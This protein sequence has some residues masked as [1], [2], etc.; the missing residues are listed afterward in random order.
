MNRL[1]FKVLGVLL[2]TSTLVQAA[3][4]QIVVQNPSE[5]DRSH[6]LVEL[7]LTKLENWIQLKEGEV[8]E[9]HNRKQEIVP[10]QVT[11]DGLLLF[12]SG[13]RQNETATFTVVSGAKQEFAPKTY[14]RFIQERKDDFAWEND[15]VAFRIYGQA[16]IPVDGPS[17]GLDVWYKR[18]N[19][20]V[21]DKWYKNDLENHIPYHNDNG[22]GLDDYKVGRTLGAGAMAPY[23]QDQLVLNENFVTPQVIENGP[24][25]TTFKLIYKP[26]VVDG[27][28]YAESRTFSIDAGSQLTKVVQEY[29]FDTPTPVA[30]GIVK[31]DTQDRPIIASD[32]SYI[33]YQEP[34]T[35]K[36]SGVTIAVLYPAGF[37]KTV[38]HSDGTSH[39]LGVTTYQPNMPVTYYTGYNW[40]EFGFKTVDEFQH[41]LE[42]FKARLAKP[43]IVT[44]K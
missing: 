15:R 12:Q 27:K 16:L 36:A 5:F 11:S 33:L 8:Y 31:R 32:K 18:T 35:D 4:L 28:T 30:A 41:Y 40:S 25:R 22:E 17:N 34:A 43:F 1:K 37:D 39:I 10:S 29:G 13:L 6:E 14:G 24:L 2:L 3:G 42:K 23:P 9:V 20:L 19:A 7:P 21:V 44:I 38:V 26:V